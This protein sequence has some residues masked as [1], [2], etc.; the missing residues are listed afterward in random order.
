M[1]T[2]LF[3]YLFF[4][5]ERSNLKK[6]KERKKKERKKETR[7]KKKERKNQIERLKESLLRISNFCS[8][9][10]FNN[11]QR[12]AFETIA[13]AFIIHNFISFFLSLFFLS[14]F[15]LSFFFLSFFLSFYTCSLSKSLW[16]VSDPPSPFPY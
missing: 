10:R 2:C 1:N 12:F 11:S 9:S 16:S 14:F 8:G 15:S 5:I 13:A 3:I 7:K 6:E 4:F